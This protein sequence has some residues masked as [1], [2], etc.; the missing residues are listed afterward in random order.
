MKVNRRLSLALV[1]TVII[2]G[3]VWFLLI[4]GKSP[5]MAGM[6]AGH[7]SDYMLMLNTG[8][9]YKVGSPNILKFMIHDKEGKVVRDFE[10]SHTKIMHFIVVRKDLANFQHLH[11][12]FD[13][14]S[15]IFTLTNLRFET[16]GPYLLFA[17]F[18]PSGATA[19]EHEHHAGMAMGQTLDVSVVAGDESKYS[20]EPLGGN[21]TS[22][23]I[24]SYLFNVTSK[25]SDLERTLEFAISENGKPVKDLQPYLG[26]LGHVV[27][28]SEGDLLYVHAHPDESAPTQAG[29][30]SFKVHFPRPGK[31]KIFAQFQHR[32]KVLTATFIEEA[33]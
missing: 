2:G 9:K 22:D 25:G 24:G 19:K 8:T 33:R 21:R 29:T 32:G 5:D 13:K 6:E 27:I 1:A 23:K 15:G 17:D 3:G 16:D 7:H 4:R 11:P 18:T 12:D 20:P 26:A 31:Y 10:T 14:E 28:L 30:V